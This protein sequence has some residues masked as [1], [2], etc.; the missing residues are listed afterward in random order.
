[1]RHHQRRGARGVVP[2]WPPALLGI[3][4]L[5]PTRAHGHEA[6]LLSAEEMLGLAAAPL[7]PLFAEPSWLGALLGAATALAFAAAV[8]ID[9]RLRPC[10]ARWSA[11][12]LVWLWPTALLA[13]RLGLGVLLVS[14]GLG[15]APRHGTELF[16]APTLFVGDLALTGA[17]AP[18]R[19][20]AGLEI[21]LGG[22]LLMGVFARVAAVLTLALLPVAFALFGAVVWAYAG[23]IAAPTL[24]I[25]CAGAGRYSL[26]DPEDRVRLLPSCALTLTVTRSLVGVTF[27]YLAIAYKL[28][29]PNLIITILERGA[30]PLFGLPVAVV[31]FIMAMVEITVGLLLIL[32]IAVRLA[33][34]AVLGAMLFLAVTL[35]EPLH[36]HANILGVLVA[37]LALGADPLPAHHV[38]APMRYPGGMVHEEAGE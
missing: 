38:T 14:A 18:Y 35:G 8:L 17:F 2:G 24:L 28:M 11:P 26:I 37:L 1:M 7:P 15:L 22:A 4:L 5:L 25:L 10:E 29:Q 30:V 27:V 12:R 32:G 31:A 36:I 33:S 3:L 34:L 19:G 16:A 13:C 9:A 6:W 21:V 20:L 23:H